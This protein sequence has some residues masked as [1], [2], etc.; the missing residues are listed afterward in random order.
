LFL[1]LLVIAL[2]LIAY[3]EEVSVSS[4]VEA[5]GS[6][7]ILPLVAANLV[8]VL[9]GVVMLRRYETCGGKVRR[10]YRIER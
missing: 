6:P 3:F 7:A 8:I 1:W 4:T 9:F 2:A 10:A 5:L